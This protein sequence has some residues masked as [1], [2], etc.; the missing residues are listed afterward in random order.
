MASGLSESDLMKYNISQSTDGS[1]NFTKY[2][3]PLAEERRRPSEEYWKLVEKLF[4]QKLLW[5]S[6]P[7]SLETGLG[8]ILDN[9][10]SKIRWS[11]KIK[12]RRKL[13]YKK[14]TFCIAIMCNFNY[15]SNS[16]G[17]TVNIE[18]VNYWNQVSVCE[19]CSSWIKPLNI[20]K[21]HRMKT[22]N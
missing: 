4:I 17:Y 13:V 16:N 14:I 15:S 2:M 6:R 11:R 3:D 7:V 21:A 10:V 20:L 1:F 22:L 18:L 9:E 8:R 5:V 12:T 19:M